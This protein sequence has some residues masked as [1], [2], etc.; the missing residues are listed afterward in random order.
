MIRGS[1]GLLLGDRVMCM[2]VWQVTHF[3]ELLLLDS[4]LHII[5]IKKVFFV[6][7]NNT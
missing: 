5:T 4:I 1:S 6:A 2:C 3:L 7:L